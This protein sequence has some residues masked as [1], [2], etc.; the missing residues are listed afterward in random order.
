MDIDMQARRIL[1]V[2]RRRETQGNFAPL[3]MEV[4]TDA[5]QVDPSTV[6]TAVELLEIRRWVLRADGPGTTVTLTDLGRV[7]GSQ[8]N[9]RESGP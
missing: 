4:I 5:L 8:S 6:R 7:V 2:L 9:P 1:Q 3:S